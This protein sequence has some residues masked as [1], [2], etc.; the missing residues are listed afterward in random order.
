MSITQSLGEKAIFQGTLKYWLP[1]LG[2]ALLIFNL[3]SRSFEGV[4]QPFPLFDKLVHAGLYAVL[5]LLLYRAL[6]N[7]GDGWWGKHA[8]A[9]SILICIFYGISDEIH[10]MY[11]PMRSPDVA[12]ILADGIGALL[13]MAG[14]RLVRSL[15]LWKDKTTPALFEG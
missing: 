9:L 15:G 5:Y 8:V 4:T 10:Q 14:L 3:S 1:P 6:I 11:V 7:V 2:W 12:D 13:S